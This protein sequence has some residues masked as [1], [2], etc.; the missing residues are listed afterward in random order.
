MEAG[1]KN[2][3]PLWLLL[4]ILVISSVSIW[5]LSVLAFDAGIA[6]LRKSADERLA[7]YDNSLQN[8]LTRME[9]LPYVMAHNDAVA[10]LLVHYDNLDQL[11]RDLESLNYWAGTASLYIMNVDGDVVASSTWREPINLIGKNYVFRP[12]FAAAKAGKQGHYFAVGLQTNKPGLYMSHG[13]SQDGQF[14][15]VVVVKA[16]LGPLLGD[17]REGREKVFITD[18]NG[19]IILSSHDE[20]LFTSANHMTP[21]RKEELLAS[22]QYSKQAL[23]SSPFHFKD[24]YGEGGRVVELDGRSYL[25]I[26]HKNQLLNWELSYLAPLKQVQQ[27]VRAVITIGAI[28]TLLV[29]ALGMYLRERRQKR[30]SS[31]K[32]REAE[33]IKEINFR[34]QEE[35]DEHYR[36]EQ[37]LRDAQAELVQSSKLAALGQMAAGIVHELNQPIAAIRTHAASGKLLVDRQDPN[38]LRETLASVSRITEHM[39]EITAQLKSFAHKSPKQGEIVNVQESLDSAVSIV[40]NILSENEVHV[41]TDVPAT[42]LYFEGSRSQLE[43]VLVNLIRNSVDAMQGEA[44]KNI[45]ISLRTGDDSLE[46][47]VV[48]TGEGIAQE[49]LDELFTPF[50]TTKE[51]GQGLG[52]GLSICYRIVNDLG[53]TIRA[54]NN[55]NGQGAVFI[56][57]LPTVVKNNEGNV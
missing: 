13:I 10:R 17:W 22:R 37:A 30:L 16:N 45:S 12:Y 43:Q 21:E 1:I 36:T 7:L 6:D 52:L 26:A 29:M 53:G 56:V 42:P 51:V 34:L 15:G 4:I 48:D 2:V 38:R 27:N 24:D 46:L 31:K 50:F 18:E 41:N 8:V 32:L 39:S 11:N 9:N 54:M 55:E 3:K 23:G 25:L 5:Q 40:A 35:I 47:K 44:E 20:W 57:S 28:L 49:D 33:T 14:L 19:V